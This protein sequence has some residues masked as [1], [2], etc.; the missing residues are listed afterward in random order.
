[1]TN[2]SAETMPVALGFHPC[3]RIP[4]IPRDQWIANIPARKIVIAD[5]RFW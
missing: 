2:L 3:Y 1:M 4:D 5:S